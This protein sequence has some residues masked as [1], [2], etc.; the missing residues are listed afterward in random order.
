MKNSKQP[1]KRSFLMNMI[2]ALT[3][4]FHTSN[5]PA[6]KDNRGGSSFGDPIFTPK[7]TKFKGYMRNPGMSSRERKNW[8]N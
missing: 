6:T 3:A 5:A 2:I 8:K 7:R 1:I 4:V